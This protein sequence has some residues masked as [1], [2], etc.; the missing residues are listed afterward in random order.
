MINLNYL[1]QKIYNND[2]SNF[3]ILYDY[4][5]EYVT[6]YINKIYDKI[7]D[8]KIYDI[9]DIQQEFWLIFFNHIINRNLYFYTED[10]FYMYIENI[11]NSIV[12]SCNDIKED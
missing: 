2:F 5:I 12:E 8:K 6:N 1:L 7:I 10:D 4:I 11:I 9:N 3:S